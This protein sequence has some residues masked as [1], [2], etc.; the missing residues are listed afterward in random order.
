MT[1]HDLEHRIRNHF[2]NDTYYSSDDV[3]NSIQDGYDET[4]VYTGLILKATTIP[5]TSLLSYYDMITLIPDFMAVVAI[6]NSVTRKWMIPTSLRKLDQVRPDWETAYGTPMYFA[7]VSHRY[8]AIFMKPLAVGYGDM[9]IFYKATAPQAADT[10]TIL[11][12]EDYNHCLID[13]V[14]S[15]LWEQNQEW[16]KAG[17]HLQAYQESL[18]DLRL[19]MKSQRLP[20]RLPGLR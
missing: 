18:E 7:P 10:D 19:W 14:I 3:V 6:F 9:Y 1:R 13:Y 8:V 17:V 20:D 11:I 12:P 16:G 4:V 5:F 2:E 15:D